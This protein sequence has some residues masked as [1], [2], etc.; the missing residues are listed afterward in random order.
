MNIN[1]DDY[2]IPM[3]QLGEKDPKNLAKYYFDICLKG[4]RLA[5]DGKDN[6]LLILKQNDMME[7]EI[8]C[9]VIHK[10]GSVIE[11][12]IPKPLFLLEDYV[13]KH[14]SNINSKAFINNFSALMKG[15]EK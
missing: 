5:L 9:C 14:S 11:N 8:E 2:T 15:S 6:V 13:A 3:P 4:C 7:Y 1:K 10:N 12:P